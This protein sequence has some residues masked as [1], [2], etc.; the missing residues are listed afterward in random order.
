MDEILISQASQERAEA[1]GRG[2]S[3]GGSESVS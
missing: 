2:R 3:T 1:A